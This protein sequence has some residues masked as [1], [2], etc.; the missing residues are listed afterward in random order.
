MSTASADIDD[1]IDTTNVG[2]V[3][4]DD[5]GPAADRWEQAQKA[6]TAPPAEKPDAKVDLP[7]KDDNGIPDELLGDKPKA[8][9]DPDANLLD[10]EPVG[11]LKHENFKKVQARAKQEIAAAKKEA[12]DMAAKIKEFEGRGSDDK[13]KAEIDQLRKDRQEMEAALERLAFERS[14][15]FQK[16]FVAR[17]KATLDR[18]TKAFTDAGGE[19][20]L[21]PEILA[22]SPARR[23]AMLDE[24]E[25][26]ASGK[27]Y[28]ISVLSEHDAIQSEKAAALAES[29]ER[30]NQW[31]TEEKA[32]QEAA[33]SQRTVEMKKLLDRTIIETAAEFEPFRKVDGN[34]AWNA[35]VDARIAEVTRIAVGE[36]TE[37]EIIQKIARGVAAD[38]IHQ[39]FKTVRDENKALRARNAELEA[40]Q[41]GA[42][43][44]AP[45]VN[46]NAN[47]TAEDRWERAQ[48]AAMAASGR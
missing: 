35:E 13:T 17:E 44:R 6:A 15:K 21:L 2:P 33:A 38:R 26:S 37:K 23:F 4:P 41:P 19:A 14:P 27:Q 1:Q 30:L 3:I 7:K 16:Q 43:G 24:L 9:V 36:S 42:G 18:A 29:R 48:A 12:A 45:A 39:M 11:P 8:E 31:E 20:A 10:A 32:Q 25:I 28:V 22:A 34:D 47:E 46:G 40:A 5:I